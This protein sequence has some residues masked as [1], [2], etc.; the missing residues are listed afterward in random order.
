M[1]P[2]IDSPFELDVLDVLPIT[3]LAAAAAP[4]TSQPQ[5]HLSQR[6]KIAAASPHKLTV[7]KTAA[8]WVLPWTL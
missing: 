1:T 2:L 3:G 7:T 8:N 5:S 4:P 6:Y